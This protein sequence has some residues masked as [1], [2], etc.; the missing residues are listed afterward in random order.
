[1]IVARGPWAR[2]C[3]SDRPR[4]AYAVH[5]RGGRSCPCVLDAMDEDNPAGM[6]FVRARGVGDH[7]EEDARA[8]L[9]AFR[10]GFDHDA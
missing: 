5:G 4:L 1:M 3:L 6:S 10:P 7:F 8:Q 2:A 9:D